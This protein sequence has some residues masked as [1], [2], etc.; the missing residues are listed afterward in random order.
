MLNNIPDSPPQASATSPGAVPNLGG[1]NG[2][3]TL[4]GDG[5]HVASQY[6]PA[7]ASDP[8]AMTAAQARMLPTPALSAQAWSAGVRS[9][10]TDFP[11]VSM[12]P[13]TA[14]TVMVLDVMPNGAPDDFYTDGKAWIDVVDTDCLTG[15]PALCCAHI[16]I[17]ST[18]VQFGSQAYNG[19]ALKPM[20]FVM[21][22]TGIAGYIDPTGKWSIGSDVTTPLTYSFTVRTSNTYDGIMAGEMVM[23]NLNGYGAGMVGHAT[24]GNDVHKYAMLVISSGA[25]YLNSW[26]GQALHFMIGHVEQAQI[27]VTG[28]ILAD[29]KDISVGS[30]TGTKIGSVSTQKLGFFGS[31]PIAQAVLA[32]GA[33]KTADDIITALQNLGLVRQS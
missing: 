7:T 11:V 1:A 21:G 32:T 6:R 2:A 10:L 3:A 25:T 18:A 5:L 12:R 29:G 15:N 17:N 28:L 24:M 23:G 14:N 26:E 27:D 4:G 33:G 22:V 30:T 8:G 31:T 16:G 19:A 20:Q 13:Q 9:H